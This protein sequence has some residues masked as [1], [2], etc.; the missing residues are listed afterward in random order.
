MRKPICYLDAVAM[1]RQF[2]VDKLPYE[3]AKFMSHHETDESYRFEY[4]AHDLYN[5]EV[6]LSVYIDFFNKEISSG[7]ILAKATT[8]EYMSSTRWTGIKRR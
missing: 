6:Q 7:V 2:I 8:E 4:L 5:R 3:D 1:A